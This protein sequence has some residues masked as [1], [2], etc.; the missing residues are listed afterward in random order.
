[1]WY[2]VVFGGAYHITTLLHTLFIFF[3]YN[4]HSL[5][6]FQTCMLQCRQNIHPVKKLMK[7]KCPNQLKVLLFHI[8]CEIINKS[9]ILHKL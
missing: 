9:K 7:Q 2:I 4:L 5:N 3:I 1:M 8:T 6:I